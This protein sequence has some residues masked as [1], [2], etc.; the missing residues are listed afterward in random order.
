MWNTKDVFYQDTCIF[1]YI[2]IFFIEQSSCIS[3][4]EINKFRCV[5][6][7]LYAHA[8]ACLVAHVHTDCERY[9]HISASSQIYINPHVHLLHHVQVY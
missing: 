8:L 4:A 5:N 1:K 2:K 9:V 6:F 7:P 3:H